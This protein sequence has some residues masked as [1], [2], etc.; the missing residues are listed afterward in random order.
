MAR[1]IPEG[2]VTGAEGG[3]RKIKP[4]ALTGCFLPSCP[5]QSVDEGVRVLT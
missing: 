2:R 1:Q 4:K 5:V 3:I